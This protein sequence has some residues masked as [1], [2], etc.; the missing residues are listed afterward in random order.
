M[1]LQTK[2]FPWSVVLN[3]ILIA[4]LFWM[5]YENGRKG[6]SAALDRET[7]LKSNDKL[8][9]EI[10]SLD[11]ARLAERSAR[12]KIGSEYD[13]S[14]ARAISEIK[15]L[16]RR[17]RLLR[18]DTITLTLTDTIFAEYDTALMHADELRKADSLSFER[19]IKILQG[20]KLALETAYDNTFNQLMTTND[21][22]IRTEKKLSK[23][24]R[25]AKVLGI[26]SATLAV[27]VAVL[28]I[29]L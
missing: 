17:E 27:I 21:N 1:N 3:L 24:E 5:W 15:A 7:L 12:E 13:A 26:S 16:K 20:S 14:R 11:S 25:L 22:L 19:E 29:A 6:E 28:A 18:P 4:L 2:L 9:T 10:R 8:K 23:M